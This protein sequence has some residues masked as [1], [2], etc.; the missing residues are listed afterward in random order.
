MATG[1]LIEIYTQWLLS[2]AFIAIT[3]NDGKIAAHAHNMPNFT[4][5]PREISEFGMINIKEKLK[6]ENFI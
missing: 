4:I 5:K 6:H 3:N 1:R 2:H